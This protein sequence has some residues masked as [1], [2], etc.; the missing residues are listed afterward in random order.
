MIDEN[1][2]FISHNDLNST[3]ENISDQTEHDLIA[4]KMLVCRSVTI[5]KFGSANVFQMA[6]NL[7]IALYYSDRAGDFMGASSKYPDRLDILKK[8]FQSE[9]RNIPNEDEFIKEIRQ[10]LVKRVDFQKCF[11]KVAQ[12]QFFDVMEKSYFAAIWTKGDN[13]GFPEVELPGSH[14]QIFKIAI[15]RFFNQARRKVAQDRGIDHRDVLTII[16]N[17][18]KMKLLPQ[19]VNKF[20]EKEIERVIIIDDCI[21]NVVL[22]SN[23]INKLSSDIEIF[24]IWLNHGKNN[25]EFENINYKIKKSVH[26][27]SDISELNS[28]LKANDVFSGGKRV[29]SIFDLDGVLFDDDIRR[30]LQTEAV[31]RVLKDKNWI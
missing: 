23:I 19:L 4:K 25:D 14:E 15:A 6:K 5:E 13:V 1:K 11:S 22:A 7:Y 3:K 9:I 20:I 26:V 30:N 29:G 8:K 16:A 21:N 2:Q 28:L 31:V 24:A 17:E 18:D 27:M 12:K 10:A